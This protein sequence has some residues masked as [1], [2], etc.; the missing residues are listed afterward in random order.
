MAPQ[1]PACHHTHSS[2]NPLPRQDS[3]F[4]NFLTT[5][6]V[7]DFRD[8]S[9]EVPPHN[10]LFR[11]GR[12]PKPPLTWPSA[13]RHT[14]PGFFCLFTTFFSITAYSSG[15]LAFTPGFA[16]YFLLPVTILHELPAVASLGVKLGRLGY[17]S[18]LCHGVTSRWR[19][20]GILWHLAHTSNDHCMLTYLFQ[21]IGVVLTCYR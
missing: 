9:A 17:W 3:C 18:V 16:P 10:E 5:D 12:Q 20:G 14:L 8:G 13:H 6:A 2:C 11:L 15:L 7:S 1:A 21:G 19:H 4:P